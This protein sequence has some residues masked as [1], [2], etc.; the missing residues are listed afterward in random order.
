MRRFTTLGI[1]SREEVLAW[2]PPHHLAYT[3]LRGFPVRHHRADVFFD[4]DSGVEPPG[5]IVTWTARFDGRVP[6]T[7]KLMELAMRALLRQF[8]RGVTRLADEDAG[9]LP[10]A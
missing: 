3:I 6:G 1:G 4:T 9:G 8:V 2:D 10:A 5:T 7:G